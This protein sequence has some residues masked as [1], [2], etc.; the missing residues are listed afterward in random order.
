MIATQAWFEMRDVRK[1]SYSTA[2][3][4]PLTGSQVLFRE[5]ETSKAGHQEEYFGCE[6]VAVPVARQAEAEQLSWDELS[7]HDHAPETEHGHYTPVDSHEDYEG[8]AFGTR[9]VIKQYLN[10]QEPDEWHLHQDLVVALQLKRKKDSWVCPREGYVEV[11]RLTRKP[12][13]EP[14]LLEIRAE[15]L[16]DYLCARSMGLFI[17]SFRSREALL[18]SAA[19]IAWPNNPQEETTS[20]QRWE[21]HVG[22]INEGG[23]RGA[24]V[25]FLHVGRIDVD[26][27]EEVPHFGF[28]GD[29]DVAMNSWQRPASGGRK[30]F[31]V[32][33]RLWRSDWLAP[34]ATSPRVRRDELPGTVPFITDALGTRETKETLTR[35][36]R[37]LW[38]R[39]QI[40]NELAHRRGGSLVWYTRETGHLAGAPDQSVHFGLNAVGLVNVYAKDIALLPEWQQQIWSG[41]S[42]SPD[43]GVSHEL[44]QSQM[45]ALPADTQAPEPFLRSILEDLNGLTQQAFGFRLFRHHDDYDDILARVHRFRAVDQPGLFELAK[46]VARLTADSIDVGAVQQQLT[47]P[48]G[49]APGS[50]KSLEKLLATKIEDDKA[51]SLLTA[52]VGIYDLRLADAHLPGST[53]TA[54][55]MQLVSLDTTLPYVWQGEH[56]IRAG[57]DSLHLI[58]LTLR[59]KFM[60]GPKTPPEAPAANAQEG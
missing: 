35:E 19:G 14:A 8:E 51:R 60:P 1:R 18:L 49:Q 6:S 17:S 12:D 11:A 36:S 20:S 13:G 3:W 38:F 30:V 15:H 5:G 54:E 44:L 41:H 58:A 52:L 45:Q 43:G 16:R 25:A 53:K 37:W 27:E 7:G 26:P 32:E 33:G 59:E 46:D 24:E 39:P 47:L 40:V 57:V 29:G 55:A 56:L 9:L 31:F 34:A 50:L 4:I 21:G 48:K 10:S 2:V 42:V 23:L 22:E 28:P